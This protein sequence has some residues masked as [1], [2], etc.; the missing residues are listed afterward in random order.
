[1]KCRI[2]GEEM[3]SEDYDGYCSACACEECGTALE[4]ENERSMGI[5][6]ECEEC[7]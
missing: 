5:C 3:V 6:E 2:C 7:T 4:T 1:M